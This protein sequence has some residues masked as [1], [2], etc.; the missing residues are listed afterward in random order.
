MK[1]VYFVAWFYTQGSLIR[2]CNSEVQYDREITSIDD[3][4]RISDDVADAY[5]LEHAPTIVSYQ[6]LRVEET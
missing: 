5:D 3:I 1:Y 2:C 4:V 6:L